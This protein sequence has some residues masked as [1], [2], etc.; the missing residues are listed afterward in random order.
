M[1]SIK[2]LLLIAGALSGTHAGDAEANP[3]SKVFELIDG[4]KA[5]IVADG[6]KEAKAYQ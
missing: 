2:V 6:E 4:L 5:T 1:H 3:L